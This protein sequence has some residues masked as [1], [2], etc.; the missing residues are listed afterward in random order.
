MGSRYLDV[1]TPILLLSIGAPAS[2]MTVLRETRCI[3]FDWGN[4]LMRN[5]P[6]YEGPRASWPE[7]ETIPH[8][9]EVLAQLCSEWMLALGTNAA[10]SDETEIRTALDLGGLGEFF[11]KIYSHQSVG[12]PKPSPEFFA[13]IAQDLGLENSALV[14]VGDDFN[15]DVLGANRAGIRGIWLNEH[16]DDHR[17]GLGYETIHELSALPRTLARGN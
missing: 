12:Y 6:A 17:V 7:A 4:T 10:N 16:S 14:M 8:A 3:I 13:F 1:R 15:T 5:V 11:D 9:R 2:E